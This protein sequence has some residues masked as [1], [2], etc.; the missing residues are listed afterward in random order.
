[1]LYNIDKV[2]GDIEG[3]RILDLG[4]GCGILSIG[5]MMLNSLC[6]FLCMLTLCSR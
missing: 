1:M 2:F 3:K 4:V 6:V 5:S